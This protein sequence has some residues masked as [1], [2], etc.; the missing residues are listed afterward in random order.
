MK[1]GQEQG[2]KNT[3]KTAKRI[4]FLR[5]VGFFRQ[6]VWFCEPFKTGGKMARILLD[7]EVNGRV[8]A[9]RI[10]G[11]D[12]GRTGKKRR[13]AKADNAGR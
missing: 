1:N 10:L 7:K 12:I 2:A 5:K 8:C 4:V 3:E 9:K 11:H 13:R 6:F